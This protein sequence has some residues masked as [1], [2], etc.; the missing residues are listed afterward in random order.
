MLFFAHYLSTLWTSVL[1][2]LR[3]TLA[4][5]QEFMD[6]S[7]LRLALAAGWSGDELMRVSGELE[8]KSKAELGARI[9]AGPPKPHVPLS[10]RQAIAEHNSFDMQLYEYGVQLFLRR[11]EAGRR[12]RRKPPGV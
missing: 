5:L 11:R 4:R 7:M 10:V 9:N 6:E 2:C 8:A 1:P 12:G 3:Y